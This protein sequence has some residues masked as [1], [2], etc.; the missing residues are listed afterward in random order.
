MIVVGVGFLKG[1]SNEGD[2]A[3]VWSCDEKLMRCSGQTRRG[4]GALWRR[5]KEVAPESESTHCVIRRE[6][7]VSRKK[8]PLELH[9]V[10]NDVIKV[11]K[12]SYYSSKPTP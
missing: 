3:L 2:A 7:L 4:F 8:K 11:I 12:I 5:I 6:M 10:L 9:S 1:Q